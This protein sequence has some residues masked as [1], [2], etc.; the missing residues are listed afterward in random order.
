MAAPLTV[1]TPADSAA[2]PAGVVVRTIETGRGRPT[3]WVAVCVVIGAVAWL[4]A[5]ALQRLF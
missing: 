5:L 2:P 4:A 3:N 1:T